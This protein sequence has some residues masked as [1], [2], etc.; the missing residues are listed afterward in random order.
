M[1]P[2]LSGSLP[3]EALGRGSKRD[4]LPLFPATKG[5]T[6]LNFSTRL[7]TNTMRRMMSSRS[8]TAT[9]HAV[10]EAQR[11]SQLEDE[12]DHKT[13]V[14]KNVKNLLDDKLKMLRK[15]VDAI[16]SDNWMYDHG[17]APAN[18]SVSRGW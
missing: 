6:E 16:E 7:S 3:E 18:P 13:Q 1:P 2:K 4:V 15:H 8:E 10:R 5:T 11:L 14:N 12:E 17:G 9:P